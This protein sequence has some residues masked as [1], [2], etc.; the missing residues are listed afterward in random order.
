MNI[1]AAMNMKVVDVVVATI[2]KIVVNV[3]ADVKMVDSV[4]VI[5]KGT[6]SCFDVPF[7]QRNIIDK[8][9]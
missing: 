7:L 6:N 9:S 3:I 8:L 2:M 4:V 1:A 5:M